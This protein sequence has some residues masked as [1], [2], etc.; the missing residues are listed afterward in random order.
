MKIKKIILTALSF[1]TVIILSVFIRNYILTKELI[2][3]IEL[4]GPSLNFSIRGDLLNFFDEFPKEKKDIERMFMRYKKYSVNSKTFLDYGYNIRYDSINNIS[5]IYSFGIDKV[6][7]KLYNIPYNTIDSLGLY[8]GSLDINVVNFLKSSNSDV[9]F[10]VIKNNKSFSTPNI[11][12]LN[13]L[14]NIKLVSEIGGAYKVSLGLDFISK[15]REK[16]FI[17]DI[18]KIE[19]KINKRNF[20]ERD[21]NKG[22]TKTVFF[23]YKNNKLFIISNDVFFKKNLNKYHLEI[24]QYFSIIDK[25]YFDYAVFPITFVEEIYKD[26]ESTMELE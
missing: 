9:I 6:D 23:R 21:Y 15:E 8:I 22:K 13:D 7:N 11:K 24:E 18:K 10:F 2:N 25:S 19:N 12:D 5:Y 16:D 26:N 1:F 20:L 4:N 14:I 3:D 17:S